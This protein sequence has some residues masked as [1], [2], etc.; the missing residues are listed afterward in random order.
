MNK[1]SDSTQ[2]PSSPASEP[3]KDPE[4]NSLS[5]EEQP[6]SLKTNPTTKAAEPL[7]E[8]PTE[9]P[10]IAVS[11]PKPPVIPNPPIPVNQQQVAIANAVCRSR[12][13]YIQGIKNTL[14][15]PSE[16][17][18]IPPVMHENTLVICIQCGASLAQIRG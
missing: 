17:P 12:G 7:P 15:A 4:Q 16:L 18:G 2:K 13:H 14:T 11:Q 8:G 1:P 9:A 6:S 3:V 5:M 10:R